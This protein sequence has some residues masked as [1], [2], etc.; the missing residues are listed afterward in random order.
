VHVIPRSAAEA[1]GRAVKADQVLV[2][3][4]QSVRAGYE[5]RA[6]ASDPGVEERAAQADPAPPAG[7]KVTS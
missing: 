3:P 6:A 7:Q 5:A 4:D 2:N 1:V